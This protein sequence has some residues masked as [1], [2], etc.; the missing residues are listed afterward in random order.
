MN[1]TIDIQASNAHANR[2]KNEYKSRGTEREWD[3]HIREYYKKLTDNINNPNAKQKELIKRARNILFDPNDKHNDIPR[4][5]MSDAERMELWKTLNELWLMSSQTIDPSNANALIDE[6]GKAANSADAMKVWKKQLALHAEK[7]ETGGM[8]N[9]FLDPTVEGHE[10]YNHH[11]QNIMTHHSNQEYDNDDAS[12]YLVYDVLYKS[13]GNERG[14]NT[15]GPPPTPM[16]GILNTPVNPTNNQ[17]GNPTNNQNSNQNGNTSNNQNNNAYDTANLD[18]LAIAQLRIVD[19]GTIS[20]QKIVAATSN[21][22]Y[23]LDKLAKKSLE[24]SNLSR[25]VKGSVL[26]NLLENENL[27]SDSLD[28]IARN[29]KRK[30][31]K[32]KV[33]K[34]LNVSQETLSYLI[35][36]SRRAVRKAVVSNPAISERDLASHSVA[37]SLTVMAEAVKHIR[38][39]RLID[40]TVQSAIEGSA[41]RKVSNYS[42]GLGPRQVRVLENAIE[43]HNTS[44]ETIEKIAEIARSST[45]KYIVDLAEEELR[46]RN[47]NPNP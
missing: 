13:W 36:D 46:R 33:A 10:Y 37:E 23:V 47:I 1:R 42:F 14:G 16:D 40:L 30:K 5:M 39:P 31:T 20:E 11:F 41:M 28:Y 44:N 45:I 4:T 26:Y 15:S 9:R 3:N 32:L 12:W 22:P 43:N 24:G 29:S 25:Y 6:T 27:N 17:N 38:D 19:N 21:N 18:P 7:I 8:Q 34:H 2:I 35:E